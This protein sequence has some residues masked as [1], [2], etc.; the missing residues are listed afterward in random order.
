MPLTI[1]LAKGKEKSLLRRHP[2]IFSGAIKS[3]QG[4][5]V[6]GET[7]D[8]VDAHGN[9]LAAAAWSENSQIRARVWSFDKNESSISPEL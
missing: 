3:T 5:A 6:S 2:W 4:Q 8:I 1:T 7:V 9:W